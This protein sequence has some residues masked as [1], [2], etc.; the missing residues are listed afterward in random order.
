MRLFEPFLEWLYHQD[1]SDLA[2]SL[3]RRTV[4]LPDADVAPHGY[5]RSGETVSEPPSTTSLAWRGRVVAAVVWGLPTLSAMALSMPL[6]SRSP[7]LEVLLEQD[8][9]G[10]AA[11]L[12]LTQVPL[13]EGEAAVGAAVD[14]P[15][16]VLHGAVGP[17][18]P[19]VRRPH[20]SACEHVALDVYEAVAAACRVALAKHSPW[21][22]RGRPAGIGA[23]RNQR[24]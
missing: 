14:A 1:L 17:G 16:R 5:R 3:S 8:L 10:V 7:A 19:G 18:A 23:G 21:A 20:D 22:P 12:Q 4:H 15:G 9:V 13:A 11:L 24:P 6:R 2:A